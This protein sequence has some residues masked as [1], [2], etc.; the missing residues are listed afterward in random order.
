MTTYD[1]SFSGVIFNL[2]G[3]LVDTSVYHYAA[4]RR[5]AN[6]LGFDINQQEH[7]TLRGLSRM[8]SLEKILEWGNV[9]LTEAEKLHMSD[10][11]NNWYKQ[12]LV[13]VTPITY[14]LESFRF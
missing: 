14:W 10:V 7:E 9:Y 2:D 11:K 5:L 3:V 6:E 1:Q 4:W 8:A 13:S 12:L